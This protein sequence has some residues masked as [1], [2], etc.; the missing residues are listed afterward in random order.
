VTRR[1]RGGGGKEIGRV[2]REGRSEN[3]EYS[4]GIFEHTHVLSSGK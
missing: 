1:N 2:E 4:L 3:K